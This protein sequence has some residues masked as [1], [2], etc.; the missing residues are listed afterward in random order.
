MLLGLFLTSHWPLLFRSLVLKPR[1]CD[2]GL[3]QNH[4]GPLLK[5][6][7]SNHAW[8]CRLRIL[9][10]DCTSVCYNFPGMVLIRASTGGTGVVSSWSLVIAD[11][12]LLQAHGSWASEPPPPSP[13]YFSLIKHYHQ[14][15]SIYFTSFFFIVNHTALGI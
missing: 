7:N 13:L 3:H 5:R 15:N 12:G 6:H 11:L 9:K 10:G 8:T 14:L 1:A 2:Q 4:L